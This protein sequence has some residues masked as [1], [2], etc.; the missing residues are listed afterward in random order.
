MK[1]NLLLTIWLAVALALSA[2]PALPQGGARHLGVSD[3]GT[4]GTDAASARAGIGA[5]AS[6]PNSDITSLSGLTTPLPASEIDVRGL[7]AALQTVYVGTGTL[8]QPSAQRVFQRD[9]RTGGT[10]GLGYG[11]VALAINLT[12]PATV[13]E[14]R[15]RDAAS[16]TT[17][18]QDWTLGTPPLA[19][20]AQTVSINVPASGHFYL[21]DLRFNTDNTSTISAT[22]KVG[23]GE[24]IG[25]AGQSLAED[26][27][28]TAASTDTTT[29]ASLGVAINPLGT[30]LAGYASNS[31]AYPP[32]ADGADVNY[33]P[34]SWVLPADG[35][36]INS[37]FAAE[38]LRLCATDIGVPCSF[39]GYAVG[40][41]GIA[42]WLPGQLHNTK[43]HA[44]LAQAGSKFG[45]FIWD[46]GHYET[47]NGNTS[48]AYLAQLQALFADLTTASSIPFNR[49]I[50]TIPAVG[51]YGNG[52]AAIEMVRQ[53]AQQ[54]V[55]SDPL[56]V[57]VDG[58]DAVEMSDLVHPS[59]AGNI[60]FARHFYRA[61]KKISGLASHGDKGPV[62]TGA[63]RAFGSRWIYLSVNQTN[64]GTAW[65]S[66]GT[67]ANQ[68]QV[69]VSGT[70]TSPFALD[71]VTPLDLS[72]PAQI[73]VQLASASVEPAAFDIWYRLPPDTSANIT[74]GVYDN[75]GDSGNGLTQGR[76]LS[77][78][79]T[80]ITALQPQVIPVVAT[81]S[82]TTVGASLS[83]SGTYSNGV[84]TAVDYSIDSGATWTSASSPTLT[85]STFAFAIPGGLPLGVYS[86]GVRDH[87]TFGAAYSNVFYVAPV[88][89]LPTLP[90]I[91]GLQFHLDASAPN[92]QFYTTVSNAAQSVSG[93]PICS[94]VDISGASINY[95]QSTTAQCPTYAV[96]V[97]N[98]MPGVR[99]TGSLNQFL[100]AV[101]P[102]WI[103]SLRSATNITALV[104]MTPTS[105]PSVAA[106]VMTAGK[107]T[108]FGGEDRLRLFQGLSTGVARGVAASD[109]VIYS[110]TVTAGYQ[111]G[112]LEKV[113][114][115]TTP[116]TV[117]LAI[118]ALTEG[119]ATISTNPAAVYDFS[120]IGASNDAGTDFLLDGY[121]HEIVIWYTAASDTQRTSLLTYATSKWGN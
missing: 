9:A 44:V 15:L 7:A 90:V 110:A 107:T 5:A 4:G 41:T 49:I 89:A 105:A 46:Q 101:S 45:S 77:L 48:P 34:A 104:V 87:A 36:V 112:T 43:L 98:A 117:K 116:T 42:S 24:V 114:T 21:I 10:F 1:R 79:A 72:N 64:G 53:T 75:V 120:D 16:P 81:I 26:F 60:T 17:T 115:R 76:Q 18:L 65:V 74:S 3:G 73:G 57:Y 6:G 59:Q 29:I 99:F 97:K 27:V 28:S 2:Q 40:G 94:H 58:I 13:S 30:V 11:A 69:F 22:S 83:V 85:G 92:G 109:T 96:N 12:Q 8:T 50:S 86:L 71:P 52:P 47:K 68:F 51:V 38:F 62:V 103:D 31:G 35:T 70:T 119:S 55:A 56:A 80:A 111:A 61:F 82:N 33:P 88:S 102:S 118:N 84:M 121:I 20:G 63:T 113:V 25:F 108:V 37:T 66:T 95:I 67:P 106:D 32:V 23:V 54:Y 14:F 93:G 19:A 100:T 39:V 91:S 78:V